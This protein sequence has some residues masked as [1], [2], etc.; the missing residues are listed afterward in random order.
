MERPLRHGKRPRSRAKRVAMVVVPA[1]LVAIIIL[2]LFFVPVSRSVVYGSVLIPAC[3]AFESLHGGSCGSAQ[4]SV[5]N[6]SFPSGGSVTV[7]WK[8]TSAVL[9]DVV[10]AESG[11]VVCRETGTAGVCHFYSSGAPCFIYLTEVGE[12]GSV[13]FSYSV[14]YGS[15]IL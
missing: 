5:A 4:S 2:I 7:N 11:S 6:M 12:T 9:L 3:A 1:G 10:I 14:S 13:V 8:S 15:Y